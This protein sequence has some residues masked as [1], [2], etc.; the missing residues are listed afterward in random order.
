LLGVLLLGCSGSTAPLADGGL[1][2]PPA[3]DGG[4]ADGGD[5]PADGGAPV[6]GGPAPISFTPIQRLYVQPRDG[7]GF[8]TTALSSATS[9][10]DAVFYILTDDT[11]ESRLISAKNRGVRVRVIL[12]PDQPANGSARARLT[13]AGVPVRGGSPSFTHTHQK[14]VLVDGRQAFI[15]TLNPSEAAFNDNREYAVSVTRMSELDD[16]GRLFEADWA[17][18]SNPPVS[19]TLVVSPNNS[20]ARLTALLQRA[21]REVLCT[22][23]TFADYGLRQLLVAKRSAGVAIRVLLAD[24]RD[25]QANAQD[26]A[27]LR[28]LGFE[29]R[30]LPR[31]FLHAKLVLVDGRYAYTGSVNLTRTSLE[32]NREVGVLVDD[33][34]AVTEL[35]TQAEADWAAGTPVP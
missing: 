7:R 5:A 4:A 2:E 11:V 17:P 31:P 35:R 6:D 14:S 30:F 34:T 20:R 9:T 15:M 13:D 22:V 10:I 1:P 25:I 12:D 21:G 27:E 19:S 8:L 16:L 32:F 18:S 33:P 28:A 3:E 29:V 24:P 23:E 26:A